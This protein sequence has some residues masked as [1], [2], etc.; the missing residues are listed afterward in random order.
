M[1]PLD[2]VLK[3]FSDLG[4]ESFVKWSGRTQAEEM[5]DLGLQKSSP[6]HTRLHQGG[7]RGW[8][9]RWGAEGRWR[10]C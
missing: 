9:S 10:A 1:C 4:K 5:E 6:G 8:G 2:L 7:W 3:S